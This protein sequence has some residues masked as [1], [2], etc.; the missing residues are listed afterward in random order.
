MSSIP[1]LLKLAVRNLGRNR[2]R[3]LLSS[4]AVSLGLALLVLMASVV[5]GEMRGAMEN[6]IQLESAHLQVRAAGYDEEK[7]S[8]DWKNLVEEPEQIVAQLEALPQVTMA[9]PRLFATGII[10]LV[11]SRGFRSS[12]SIRTPTPISASGGASSTATSCRRL[13]ARAS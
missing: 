10:T 11:T 4:L 7:V 9:T 1:Q 8:L 5:A 2:R 12:A 3:S 13:T 6:T